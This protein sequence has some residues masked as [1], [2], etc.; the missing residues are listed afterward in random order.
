MKTNPTETLQYTSEN[1]GIDVLVP[2][3]NG[4]LLKNIF[5]QM[6]T[7]IKALIRW[8][9]LML[10]IFASVEV[11]LGQITGLIISKTGPVTANPGELVTYTITFFNNG[12]K[13]AKDVKLEDNLPAA[14]LFTFVSASE[15]G[16]FNP[17]TRKVTWTKNELPVLGYLA[18]NEK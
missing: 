11:A 17:V 9:C 14:D 4:V 1:G 15:G 5:L 10:M 2:L 16:I 6:K 18:A 7:K 12:A 13:L 8:S 3:V